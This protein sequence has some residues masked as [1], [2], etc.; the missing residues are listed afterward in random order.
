[1]CYNKVDEVLGG[2][3]MSKKNKNQEEPWSRRFGEDESNN[4]RQYSRSARKYKKKEVA[5]LY[6]VILFV[7]LALLV[8]PFATYAW[9]EKTKKDPEPQT[10]E[11]VMIKKPQSA[12]SS[13]GS[14]VSSEEESSEES[15]SSS[16]SVDEQSSE[17]R[18]IE[19]EE[20]PESL[21]PSSEAT[22]PVES[23][24]VE[25]EPND[26]VYSNTYTIK[27]GDNLYRIAVNHGMTL[28]ELKEAN[29]LTSEVAE[30]GV[31]LKVK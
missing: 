28:D 1:M 7:F 18:P 4:T 15:V 26:G 13:S 23:T 24:P 6:K 29:G 9:S 3:W 17:S 10:A 5:P 14:Q 27:A 12:Q 25:E 20:K 16:E 30:I 8:I 2:K 31:V 21:T 19:S 11:Q 22:P